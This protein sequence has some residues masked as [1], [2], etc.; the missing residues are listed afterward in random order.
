MDPNPKLIDRINNR[1][2]GRGLK[3]RDCKYLPYAI[4]RDV[5]EELAVGEEVYVISSDIKGIKPKKGK[6][7]TRMVWVAKG[8][9]RWGRGVKPEEEGSYLVFLR[10][11]TP[12]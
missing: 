4:T 2:I 1:H 10:D 7:D 8:P 5:G 9:S 12:I 11:L 6:V 3:G